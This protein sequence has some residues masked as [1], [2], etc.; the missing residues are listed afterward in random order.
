MKVWLLNCHKNSRSIMKSSSL[1]LALLML[2]FVMAWTTG[3]RAGGSQQ[4][5]ARSGW[6]HVKWGDRTSG[7][8]PQST[9]R[10]FLLDDYGN[11][12][13][14]QFDDK[15]VGPSG[16][17]LVF[18]RKRVQI[19]G[20]QTSASEGGIKVRSMT[21]EKP[22]VAEVG[23]PGTNAVL[24]NKKWVTILCRFQ[25]SPSTPNPVSFFQGLM[26]NT[27]PGMDHYWQETSYGKIWLTGSVVVG[28]YN[29][30]QPRSYYVYGNPL[31][32]DFSRA[33]ADATTVAD[34]DVNFPDFYG[35]N[36]IFNEPL[37][38]FSWGGVTFVSKDGL[39]S[40]MFG[41]TDLSPD[42]YGNRKLVAHEMGH[43]FGLHHS[44][45]PYST[46]Y[47]SQWD[48]MSYVGPCSSPNPIY[49][50]VG[51]HTIS[52]HKDM[53]GWI[54]SG[55]K[56]LAAAGTTATINI[57]RLGQPVS[58]S[59]YLM[60][61]IP[62]D[63]PGTKFY[64]VEARFPAGYDSQI[65]GQAIVIHLVDTTRIDR[66]AQ[67]VDADNNGDPNDGGAMWLPG[68]SFTDAAHGIQVSINSINASSFS[69]TIANT[70]AYSLSPTGRSFS[71]GGGTDIINVTTNASCP[72][73]A[74]SNVG[75]ITVTS[76]LSGSG[77]G[78]VAYSVAPNTTSA[79]RSGTLSV[80]GQSFTVTQAAPLPP[81]TL[82]LFIDE[83]SGRAAA[84]DSVTFVSQ[85]FSII[86][87]YNFSSDQRTRV[88]LFASNVAPG[89][90]LALVT[91]QAEDAQHRIHPLVVEFV[92]RVPN[93]DWLTQ[94][95][96][97]LPDDLTHAGD[98]QVSI[99]LRGEVSNKVVLNI[100]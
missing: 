73:A 100:R 17:P 54:P 62:I 46:P 98:V 88:I 97:V 56:Y 30:P 78:P 87:P 18:D 65:P 40:Q 61:Q 22:S 29:L 10:Y 69:V 44:S 41:A 11:S 35:I 70:C 6:F 79:S 1:L 27:A 92:G 39:N 90:N 26:S 47:D 19:L 99:S 45:G 31:R 75:W 12:T 2:C 64:T 3:S 89:D 5:V 25:D 53:L 20:E 76:G 4:T 13:E 23:T 7:S 49:G 71:A 82:T 83:T 42:G 67:V 74:S 37:D 94:M 38:G 15:F 36:F 51:A 58:G 63:G 68:E 60:A 8:A 85:P 9:I 43:G 81:A 50:C 86:T 52:Y 91:A 32:V 28:W 59:N 48:P 72:W 24:G 93:F 84:L 21:L 55:R 96:V 34:P 57:E 77:N 16:G 80:A 66:T 14:L 33:E 95:N